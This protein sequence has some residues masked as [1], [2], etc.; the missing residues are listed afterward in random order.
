MSP[1]LIETARAA[2]VA[3]AAEQRKIA[4]AIERK[5]SLQRDLDAAADE[6]ARLSAA[7][8]ADAAVRILDGDT[9]APEKPKRQ[10]RIANLRKRRPQI[11]AAISLQDRRIRAATDEIAKFDPPLAAA[12]FAVVGELSSSA[13]SEIRENLAA[14]AQAASRLLAADQVMA[15]ILGTGGFKV[16]KGAPLPVNGG[17]LL[18]SFLKSVPPALRPEE[19][20]PDKL[21]HAAREISQPLLNNV[22]GQN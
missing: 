15:G 21:F 17:R 7:E 9:A 10:T 5:A 6:E 8:E 18:E 16:P 22:K 2:F 1:D 20:Q 13:I 14:V 19:L 11:V 3:R 12:T 4:D